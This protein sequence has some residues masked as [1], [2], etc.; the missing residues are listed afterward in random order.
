MIDEPIGKKTV[1]NEHQAL[2]D[3]LRTLGERS[4]QIMIHAL[5]AA[6]IESKVNHPEHY[7]LSEARCAGC[8]QQ[9]ECIEV[10]HTFPF[11][12]GNVIKYIWRHEHKDGIE[13][14]KKAQFYLND[15]IAR[16]ENDEKI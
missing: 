14:L 3:W 4:D 6:D 13:A 7:N 12:L 1:I 2:P 15:Y 10:A 9:I 8:G 5:E 16:M 11:H